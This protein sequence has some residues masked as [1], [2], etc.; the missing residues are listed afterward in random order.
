[1]QVGGDHYRGREY[2][3]WD[4]IDRNGIG[5]LEGVASKYVCRYKEKSGLQDLKKAEHYVMKL[6]EEV[7]EHNRRPRGAA[8]EKELHGLRVGYDLDATAYGAVHCLLTWSEMD[9][10]QAALKDVQDLI[11]V[12]EQATSPQS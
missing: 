8:T 12:T 9:H 2:Q 1:M 3:H 10:L 5:Y 4:V 6:M 7:Q 11:M